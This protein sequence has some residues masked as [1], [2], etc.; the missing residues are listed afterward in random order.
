MIIAK[1][2]KKDT[3]LKAPTKYVI[4]EAKLSITWIGNQ[5]NIKGPISRWINE[6]LFF[7][8][9][10]KSEQNTAYSDHAMHKEYGK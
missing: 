7:I 5:I 9:I 4:I 10:I 6:Q 8:I 2:T 3:G 1:P